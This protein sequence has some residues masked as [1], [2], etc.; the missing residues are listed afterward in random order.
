MPRSLW[1]WLGGLWEKEASLTI[2]QGRYDSASLVAQLDRQL[3]SQDLAGNWVLKFDVASK[4]L[5]IDD[6]DALLPQ[7]LAEHKTAAALLRSFLG[8]IGRL[9]DSL[10]AD[11]EAR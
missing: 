6:F 2:R 5:D 3:P 9:D 4:E 8:Q 11:C 1:Q 7:A 10:Q